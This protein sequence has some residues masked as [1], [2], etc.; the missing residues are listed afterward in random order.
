MSDSTKHKP[1]TDRE[2]YGYAPAER[3]PEVGNGPYE[4]GHHRPWSDWAGAVVAIALK[5]GLLTK[6]SKCLHCEEPGA[7]VLQAHH[8][9]YDKPLDVI[10]LCQYHH[11]TLYPS[12]PPARPWNEENL[13][14]AEYVNKH[15][16]ERK[17]Q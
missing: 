10:W 7:S 17:T 1:K 12:V 2:M 6:P 16:T 3:Y 9:D 5:R 13:S 4:G 14:P 8:E 15:P 11:Q